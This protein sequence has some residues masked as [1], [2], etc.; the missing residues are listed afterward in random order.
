MV[1]LDGVASSAARADRRGHS[2]VRSS[3]ITVQV[4]G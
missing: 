3:E 4:V 2:I 1:L